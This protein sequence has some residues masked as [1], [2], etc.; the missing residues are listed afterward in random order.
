M[1][2]RPF[3]AA[4]Q[5]LRRASLPRPTLTADLPVLS[6]RED[7][8]HALRDHQ[9]VIISGET[10][11]GKTTQ[12]PQ[13]CLLLERGIAGMIGCTQPRRV[14]ARSVAQRLAQELGCSLGEQ[15]GFQVRFQEQVS[16]RTHIKVMTEGI[17]LAETASDPDLLR[18]D[19]LIL[20]EVHERSLNM[21]FLLGYLKLLLPRRPDLK[22]VLTSATMEADR[23]AAHFDQ[24][25]LIEVSGRTWPVEIR[26]RPITPGKAD[27]E[28]DEDQETLALLQAVDELSL[29]PMGDILVFMPGERDIRRAAEALRQ[30]HPPHTEILPLYARQ[31]FAEQ[32]RVFQ[33]ALGRRIIL[34]TNV[35]ETSLTVPGVRYVVDTGVARLNRYSLR[36]KVNQLRVEPISQASARQRAGRCG[37]L[38]AGVCIRLYSE[39]DHAARP[40]FTAPEILRS[41]LAQVILRLSL[42]NIGGMDTL[43]LLDKPSLRAIEEGYR[44]LQ[45][46]DAVDEQRQLTRLGHDLAQLPVDPRLGRMVLAAREGG[47]LQEIL[48]LVA[49]LSVQ[50]PRE[51]PFQDR[52]KADA[53]HRQWLRDGSEFLA[54]LA[55]W[56]N[57]QETLH[58]KKFSRQLTTVCRQHYLSARRVREWREVHGQLKGWI[59]ERGWI[60]NEQPATAEQVHRALLTGLLDQIG[61][62][63]REA[64]NYLGP[65]GIRFWLTGAPKSKERARWIMAGE[66]AETERIQARLIAPLQPEWIEAAAGNL[67]QRS[68]GDPH[69]DEAGEQ[70]NAYEKVTLLGLTLV[71]RR[72][73]RYGPIAPEEARRLFIRHALV[74]NR[75]RQPPPFLLRNQ[76]TIDSVLELEHKRRRQ[77]YLIDDDDQVAFYA[78]LLPPDIWSGQ[79]LQRWLQK[80]SAQDPDPLHMTPEFLLRHRVDEVPAALYPDHLEWAGQ[81]W[82]LTY[83]FEP[84]HPLDG[85]TL[86]LPREALPLLDQAPLDWL[87]PG[88]IRDKLTACFKA[89]P[90]SQRRSL[91]PLPGAVTA[92]LERHGPSQGALLPQLTAFVRQRTGQ[93]LPLD[94]EERLPHHLSM[95]LSLLDE[96][97][98]EWQSG[99][100]PT[101]LRQ[102]WTAMLQRPEASISGPDWVTSQLTQWSFSNWPAAT[103]VRRGNL[104]VPVYA[105]LVDRGESVDLLALDSMVEADAVSHA[106]LRRLARLALRPLLSKGANSLPGLLELLALCQPHCPGMTAND[107]FEQLVERVMRQWHSDVDPLPRQPAEY[108]RQLQSLKTRWHDSL[109]QQMA[110]SHQ[111]FSD[112]R[113]IRNRLNRLERQRDLQGSLRQIDEHQ[114]AL[115]DQ[116]LE[117]TLPHTQR[118]QIPRYL[119]GLRLRL[120]KLPLDPLLDARKFSDWLRLKRRWQEAWQR[121]PDHPA[122]ARFRWLMEEWHVA[123]FAQSLPVA[124]PVSLQR[125]EKFWQQHLPKPR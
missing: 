104:S 2:R 88:L 46:L 115:V 99:R 10:G 5:E 73:V 1:S 14:A 110:L 22:L 27:D 111:I 122:L 72:A 91:V 90:S 18:Y 87:V 81:C 30:H 60:I 95:R 36:T 34:A 96:Q 112:Q 4:Q 71:G 19:T 62:W 80:R 8:L 32:E 124:Q 77:G 65:R 118:Q 48:I 108:Q 26:W 89:L 125:L 6:A 69:W 63:D 64:Q 31:S 93:P 35:A 82:P 121:H 56:E 28:P 117:A 101:L 16:P 86:T 107:L 15:V 116:A 51:R 42:L 68:Y 23:L 79:R 98:E 49:A 3:S 100:N 109:T 76:A 7:I 75:L 44:Q 12:L 11:S 102:S 52:Q 45:A 57:L 84:G 105:A 120:E 83:R 74:D 9:V 106:G 92:F 58:H 114:R 39:A 50:D 40:P 70:I 94:L 38:A 25:P 33:P 41:S 43:P 55:V 21:D 20:D 17:L 103:E 85:V 29:L 61:Q 59:A 53:H 123:L 119:Q 67:L 97:G 54:L 13:L 47:C 66:M 113:E 37:R 78:D 24:A